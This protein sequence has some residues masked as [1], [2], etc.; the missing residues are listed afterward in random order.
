MVNHGQTNGGGESA[1]KVGIR[2]FRENL[3]RYIESS[4]PVAITKHGETV[5]YYIP[6]KPRPEE[7]E[8]NALIAASEKMQV[9]LKEM[10]V[11]ED[12]LVEEY[13]QLKKADHLKDGLI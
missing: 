8:A 10:N 4:S 7:R 3:S 11:T 2:E 9:L 5:G 13:K 12:E 6:T 1:H